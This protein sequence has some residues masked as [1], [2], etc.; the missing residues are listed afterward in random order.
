MFIAPL[1]TAQPALQRSAM[2]PAMTAPVEH[3][4][5]PLSEQNLFAVARSINISPLRDDESGSKARNITWRSSMFGWPMR[6]SRTMRSTG[7]SCSF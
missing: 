4:F 2:F 1:L 7:A 3:R 6:W 5:A